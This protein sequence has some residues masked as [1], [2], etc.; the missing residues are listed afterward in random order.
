MAHVSGC[1]ESVWAQAALPSLSACSPASPWA[2]PAVNPSR[3]PLA[4]SS[5]RHARVNSAQVQAMATGKRAF[6]AAVEVGHALC[7]RVI[8]GRAMQ[9]QTLTASSNCRFA[10]QHSQTCASS[11]SIILMSLGLKLVFSSS[12]FLGPMRHCAQQH[13]PARLQKGITLRR[14]QRDKASTVAAAWRQAT[15]SRQK[16]HECSPDHSTSS[17]KKTVYQTSRGAQRVLCFSHLSTASAVSKLSV[18]NPKCLVSQNN[19]FCK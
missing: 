7:H 2:V 13:W 5:P 10:H 1:F 3:R 11:L 9:S 17:M 14:T 4:Q 16:L 6:K 8:V 12:R 19:R 15:L 18:M